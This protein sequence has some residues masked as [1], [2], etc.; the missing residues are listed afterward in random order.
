VDP[1]IRKAQWLLDQI[2]DEDLRAEMLASPGEL[3]QPSEDLQMCR[4]ANRTF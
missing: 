2:V 1:E 4:G 3:A